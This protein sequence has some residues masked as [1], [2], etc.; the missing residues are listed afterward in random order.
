MLWGILLT[1]SRFVSICLRLLDYFETTIGSLLLYKFERP[2]FNDLVEKLKREVE[3]DA[4][5]T[6]YFSLNIIS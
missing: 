3:A 4:E 6:G 2:M 1:F 5:N